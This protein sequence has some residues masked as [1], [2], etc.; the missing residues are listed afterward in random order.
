ME[1]DIIFINSIDIEII[2]ASEYVTDVNSCFHN[3]DS[4]PKFV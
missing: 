3:L 2:D 1:E 4:I